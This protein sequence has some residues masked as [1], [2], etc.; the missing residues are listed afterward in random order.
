M[1][2][3]A[4]AMV[5]TAQDIFGQEK[6]QPFKP[7][8]IIE[9][10]TNSGSVEELKDNMNTIIASIYDN[11]PQKDSICSPVISLIAQEYANPD[12]SVSYISEKVHLHPN[13]LSTC[14]KKQY[15]IGLL[16][17]ITNVRLKT[18]KELLI[19]THLTLDEIAVRVGY[20]S[21]QPLSRAFKKKEGVP[22]SVY[23]TVNS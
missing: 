19:T 3:I 15:G 2:D 14:F 6:N 9:K 23:R 21:S 22:P 17:Y 18:A 10:I 13:Y 16:E 1:F 8:Y 7:L 11:L 20:T 4:G 5:K 12:L